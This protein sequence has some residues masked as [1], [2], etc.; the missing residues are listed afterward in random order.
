MTSL[1]AKRIVFVTFPGLKLLDLTGPVQVFTDANLYA[2]DTYEVRVVSLSGGEIGTDTIIAVKT[3]ALSLAATDPVDTL[4]VVGGGGAYQAAQDKAL[5]DA[6]RRLASTSRRV[7]SVCTGAFVLAAA[8]L[9][10]GRSAVTHWESCERLQMEYPDIDVVA[11]AIFVRDGKVRTSAGVTAGIDLCLDMVV[12][13][14]GRHAALSLA[15]SLVCYLVRPGG[16]SQFSTPLQQQAQGASDK[17]DGLN[18]WIPENLGA[19]L[20]V[21][22]LAEREGMSPRNFSRLYRQHTG[23]TPAKAVEAFRI[24]AACRLLEETEVSLTSIAGQCGFYDDERLRRALMRAKGV[25]PGEYRQRFGRL[26]ASA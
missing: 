10:T 23:M 16:Q 18:A 21:E 19:N 17:F 12:E 6:V 24:E 2:P 25:A 4:I 3:E 7:V 8:G 1:S 20:S 13:D 15:R 9:L 14:I 11:D 22:A 26:R 5:L